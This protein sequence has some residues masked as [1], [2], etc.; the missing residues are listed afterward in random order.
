M[1]K[2]FLRLVTL[3]SIMIL[4]DY[5][6]ER[7]V[8]MGFNYNDLTLLRFIQKRHSIP[9]A[10]A[11]L[12]FGKNESSIRRAIEQINL[13]FPSPVIEIEKGICSSCLSYEELIFLIRSMAPTDYASSSNERIRVI[14][15]T[16]FF[17]GYI[18]ASE[19]YGQWNL[20]LTTKKQDTGH[21]RRFLDKYGLSLTTLHKKGLTIEGDELQFCFLV[22]DILHPLLE[23]T[24]ENR[25]QARFANTPIERQSFELAMSYL[26]KGFSS[27]AGKLAHFL[28]TNHLALNYP[29]KKFLL[30]FICIMET[31]PL[32][33]DTSF[34]CRL[35]FKP[36]DLHL[37][38]SILENKLYNVAFSMQNFS[39][40]PSLPFDPRLWQVTERFAESVVN[41][42]SQPFSVGE[43]FLTEL[44]EYFYREITLDYFHCTFVD[45]TVENTAGKFPVLYEQIR[46]YGI[47]F[48]AAYNFSLLDEHLSTLTLMVEK[49]IIKNRIAERR[50]K[51]I[52]IM[53]SINFERISF[54]LEQLREYVTFQWVETLNLN[55]IHRL[56]DL[57]Y[58]YIFCF[59]TRIC[60]ILSSR[61]LPVIRV[62]FFLDNKDIDQLLQM[63][64]SAQTHRF[65]ANS[66][67][68]DLAGKSEEEMVYFLKEQFGDYFV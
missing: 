64:F 40:S 2:N 27:A 18:N 31:R 35:P 60:N 29:S 25:V 49:H 59:S 13:S 9:L 3:I 62:N 61:K 24:P 56:N 5:S 67:A 38:D 6:F 53:T 22:I 33:P 65:C 21:L 10:K 48:Q 41:G 57:S 30:L 12:Q 28:K 52:I 50:R 68:L 16:I 26:E 45:K 63:G 55:E 39:K 34:S 7:G 11:A 23:F 4:S 32:K 51:R 54:F 1:Y 17:C 46:R 58:D 42:L 43:D 8:S 20:S 15:V 66:F 44:Y 47:Y 36:L 19:L 37:T 14:V